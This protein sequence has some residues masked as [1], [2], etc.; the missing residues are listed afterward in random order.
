[1]QALCES[2]GGTVFDY[3]DDF[4]T[5]TLANYDTE[6][7]K[8]TCGFDWDDIN[9]QLIVSCSGGDCSNYHARL[10]PKNIDLKNSIVGCDFKIV[11]QYD[12]DTR[13]RIIA[14][15]RNSSENYIAMYSTKNY[16]YS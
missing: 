11:K 14:R 15:Y 9:K 3:F 5:N 13:F 8:A 2:N 10:Y 7:S 16:V 12:S 6:C 1:M 4:S